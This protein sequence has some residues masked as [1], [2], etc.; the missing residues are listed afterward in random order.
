[1]EAEK[2]LL[3]GV[4]TKTLNKTDEEISELLYQKAEDS[5]EMILV[6]GAIN[7]VLDADKSRVSQIKKSAK[8]DDKALNDQYLKG[9]KEGKA[10]LEV[11]IKTL[12]GLETNAIG[13]DLVKEAVNHLSDCNV[14]T[15]EQIKASSI[16]V[17][18]EKDRVP[19]EKYD[20]ME[21]E[22]SDFKLNHDK[23]QTFTRI[24]SDVL[25]IF[26][27]L[28]PVVSENQAV[29][30]TRQR[31]FLSK[32]K[33]Y[34]YDIAEDGNHFVKKNG[35]RIEDEH[36]NPVKFADFVKEVASLNYDF[37]ASDDLG[38]SGNNNDGNSSHVS[39]GAPKDEK[40]YHAQLAEL[41]KITDSNERTKKT[42]E[43]S[44]AWKES[45][46]N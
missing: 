36:S 21:K 7:L 9:K 29:A 22:Y 8:P 1:M 18:L 38:N 34:D 35:A 14:P 27:G 12:T 45:Q 6:D 24:E 31:D 17:A 33:A 19:K 46:K 30:S 37:N 28:N 3:M 5:E 43:L 11:E 15:D 26:T 41:W 44:K 32:F 4:L 10:E 16:Y 13:A 42:T 40:E 39:V 2:D 25:T 23:N 20:T